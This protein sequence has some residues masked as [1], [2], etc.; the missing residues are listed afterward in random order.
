MI[1]QPL[2]GMQGQVTDMEISYKLIKDM[3]KQLY[4]I[5]RLIPDSPFEKI[6]EDCD[7]DNWMT[8]AQ[9]KEYTDRRSP[10]PEQSEERRI[11]FGEDPSFSLKLQ[12]VRIFDL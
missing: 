6:E 4:D 12:K 3:Q 2:G 11:K 7:R 9:A 1:H 8:A 10:R 5:W